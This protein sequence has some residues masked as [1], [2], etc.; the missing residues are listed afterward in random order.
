MS[1]VSEQVRT[2][3]RQ[4]DDLRDAGLTTPADV[5]R[6]D[7]I[8]YGSDPVWQTLDVYRPRQAGGIQLPVI[9]SVHG[10]AWVYGDKT[11][12]QYYCMSLAQ[13]GFAVVNFSYR[14]A[15]E[16]KF[17][18][19]LEDCNLVFTWVLDHAEEYGL[20]PERVFAVGDSAGGHLLGLFLALC[21]DP[22][23][24]KEFPFAP[25]PSFV[26]KGVAMNCGYYRFTGD[27]DEQTA[28]LLADL[29]PQRGTQREL[30]QID[31]LSH[32]NSRFPPVF[33][34]TSTGDFLQDQ[35]L[36]LAKVLVQHSV[37]FVFRFYGDALHRLEHVF[38]CN[39]RSP[40][41]IRCNQDECDFFKELIV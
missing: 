6:F 29:L 32:V 24:R 5:L 14:L 12:Y 22:A 38:H 41:G 27:G 35:A 10:G 19:S 17:P 36:M 13:H 25:P 20:D 16:F 33:V 15:P 34:M 3:F 4:G 26:P 8:L 1:N 37:P 31:V 28:A 7:D 2:R 11:R 23:F 21:T 30:R 18:A 39:V 40:E 9:V